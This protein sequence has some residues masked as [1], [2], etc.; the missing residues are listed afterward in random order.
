[1]T[2]DESRTVRW[3]RLIV[4]ASALCWVSAMVWGRGFNYDEI[5]FFRASDWI[6]QGLVPYRDFWE[7]HTAL[8]WYLFAPFTRI[9]RDGGVAPLIVVR[10]LQALLWIP[11]L[12]VL[13]LWNREAGV[14]RWASWTSIALLVTSHTFVLK[15][16][17]FRVDTVAA[18]S[19]VIAVFALAWRR[20]TTACIVAGACLVLAV[21]ANVR[22][23]PVVAAALV[24]GLFIQ[25]RIAG[26]FA[27]ALATSLIYVAYLFAT[28]SAAAAWNQVI[29]QNAFGD[30]F[31]V[32]SLSQ[33]AA[34]FARILG[35]FHPG[36]ID[37]AA[38]ALYLCGVIGIVYAVRAWRPFG[39]W[40]FLAILQAVSVFAL[41]R[42]KVT[43]LYHLEII[44][45][46]MVPLAAVAIDRTSETLRKP[47]FVVC[48][49][50]LCLLVFVSVFRSSHSVLET[51]SRLVRD[52]NVR[53]KGLRVLDSVGYAYDTRPAWR[54][55]FVP[56]LVEN[57]IRQH[58]AP[59]LDTIALAHDPPAALVYTFRTYRFLSWQPELMSYVTHHYVP[60]KRFEWLSGLSALV[61][62]QETATWIAPYTGDYRVYASTTLG[63]HPWFRQPLSTASASDPL[64]EI[65]LPRFTDSVASLEFI[66]DGKP[67]AVVNGVIHLTTQSPLE[68][69]S[70]ADGV[71]IV[72]MPSSD[73]FLFTRLDDDASIEASDLLPPARSPWR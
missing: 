19:F 3:L 65:D 58:I 47:L 33:R 32:Q 4:A 69:R 10:C 57:M 11:A 38:V 15:A 67:V 23:L 63:R 66:A 52:L 44:S 24:L 6:R 28:G 62:R 39:A 17:E 26:L 22:F 1:M 21:L 13:H 5:E 53:A 51:Q 70:R 27:G 30:Q 55:W 18:L 49:A 48:V 36:D 72:L 68:C 61:S 34:I 46:L 9:G 43:Y 42:M 64:L 37:I 20:T 31:A 29:V 41:L 8:S 40:Q 7:H 54:Y 2:A 45:L 59:P 73:R 71:G 25:K 60:V 35:A 56:L 16:I 50:S 14:S 12:R